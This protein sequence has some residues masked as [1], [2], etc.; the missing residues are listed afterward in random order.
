VQ[1]LRIVADFDGLEMLGDFWPLF[2][3]APMEHLAP[4]LL[5]LLAMAEDD[6]RLRQLVESTKRLGQELETRVAWKAVESPTV[7]KRNG[8]IK[9]GL[10]S[11]DFR[12]HSAARCIMPLLRDYDRGRIDMRCYS[13]VTAETDLLQEKM[14]GM[15]DEFI[16]ISKL[17]D[18]AA[19][20]RIRADGVD[21]LFDLMGWTAFS[22]LP[23]FAYRPAPRQVSWLG[24]PFT[25]GLPSI[26]YLLVD[27]FNAPT[28]KSLSPEKPL[29][30][31]GSWAC[32]DNLTDTPIG[33][34]PFQRNGHITFGTL[35]NTYKISRKQIALWARI[36]AAVP[37]SRFLMARVEVRSLLFCGNIVNEF[38]K[39]GISQDRLELIGQA[40]DYD[41][42]FNFYNQFDI[43]L[44]TYPVVGGVTTMDSLWMG[45]PVVAMYGAAFHQRIGHSILNHCG[46]GEFSVP[47]P[48][49]F[50][51][52]ACRLAAD[53]DRLAELHAELRPRFQASPLF[54][55]PGFAKRFGD[56]VAGLVD[57]SL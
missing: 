16:E 47:T 10:V 30:M 24:W 31:D 18:S 56:A 7:V 49:A 48:E 19:A 34:S 14:K 43:S 4:A 12:Q 20:D 46:L 55:G 27:R 22:R 1:I 13:A 42:H 25:S 5:T 9:V 33:A 23:L 38:A 54:D 41:G 26:E 35:N 44:D 50:I 2:D 15:C 6:D 53:T 52:T 28:D 32:F 17:D 11:A 37:G 57:A 40:P 3:A 51:E 8:R 45:V 36:M 39:H 29:I 21:V